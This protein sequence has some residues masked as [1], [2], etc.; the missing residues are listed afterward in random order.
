MVGEVRE[1]DE[2][3]RLYGKTF[4][5]TPYLFFRG[6]VVISRNLSVPDSKTGKFLHGEVLWR[7]T[8][9]VHPFFVHPPAG[10][11]AFGFVRNDRF[12]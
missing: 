7:S 12:S 1:F 6:P 5:T 2:F 9:P 8:V 4:F 11:W 3:V 10:H